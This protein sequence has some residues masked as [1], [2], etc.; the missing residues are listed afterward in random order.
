MRKVKYIVFVFLA[1]IISCKKSDLELVPY[2]Q[3]ETPVLLE[4]KTENDV[5]IAVNGMYAGLKTS[6]SY[7]VNGTW[8]IMA[9]VLADNLIT[10]Q[11]GPG[12]G[13]LRSFANWQ[14]TGENTY[15]LFAGGYTIIRRAN[16]ILENIDKFPAGAF[17]DNAKGEAL[18]IRAMTYFDM[19]RVFSKTYLNAT[20]TDSTMPYIT[21]TA[22]DN[23]PA[24]E[25]V[26]GFYDK[27]IADLELAKTLVGT[28]NGLYR[29]NKLSVSA[30]LSRVY[31]YKGDWAKC[32]Q[33]SNDALGT[34]PSL[35][36]RASFASIW[37]DADASSTTIPS[38]G[39]FFKVRN[40]NLD[41][42]NSQ[43]V[44]YYQTVQGFR[45]SEFLVE[46]NFKQLFVA[47]DIRTSTYI[48]TSPFNGANANHVIKYAGRTGSP[49]G[50][51]DG[52]VIRTAEVL[53]NRAEAYYRSTDETNALADLVLL[54]SNRYTGYVPETLT[55]LPLLNEIVKQ[56][57]LELAFEGDRFW[58]LKRRNQPVVRDGTKGDLADGTGY[59]YI[60]TSLP[61]GDYKF[62]LPFPQE[63]INFNTKLTQNPNY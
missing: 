48:A 52:K 12:R 25:P 36:D 46:Y 54:K 18:A 37:R 33:A 45:K 10:N 4:L 34:T 61:A 31:L 58:D 35:P 16:A 30:L 38:L 5:N 8:N 63:E 44:N 41:N 62:Q 49:A 15:G 24:K 17:K 56:R 20:A 13:T 26:H 42:V 55:G 6:A 21:T 27:V 39:V 9:D 43:G 47:S 40:T 60:F 28:T 19:V 50:V 51:V 14:Y 11:S 53:L 57:R 22:R 23:M 1:G 32:I 2:N 29:V 3:I 7:F 59:P